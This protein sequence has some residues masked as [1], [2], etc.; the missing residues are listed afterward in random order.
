M[1]WAELRELQRKQRKKKKVDT[2]ASKGRKLRYHVHEKLL[3]FMAPEPRGTWHESMV[4]ELFG[5]LFGVKL[6]S[7]EQTGGSG[8]R[9]DEMNVDGDIVVPND[10]LKLFG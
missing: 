1:K 10:G 3:N 4:E 8:D 7:S 2:K 6:A 9:S 5:S